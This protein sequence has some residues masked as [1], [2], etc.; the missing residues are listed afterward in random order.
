MILVCVAALAAVGGAWWAVDALVLT[1]TTPDAA[2]SADA[3]VQ[4]VV[5]PKGLPRRDSGAAV[6][7]LQELL[8][9]LLSDANFRDSFASALRRSTP[10]EQA[11]FREHVFDAFKPKLMADIRRY[12]ELQGDARTAFLDERL[13][14]FKRMEMLSRGAKIDKAAFADAAGDQAALLK[15]LLTKTTDEE[16]A[17]GAAYIRAAVAR[18][19]EIRQEPETLAAFEARLESR[20]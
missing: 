7:T 3:W 8:A 2:S 19:N 5:D 12:H 6:Q 15:L 20:R 9:R 4:Y 13:V 11:A 10:E 14:D 1:P 16:R 17:L 18:W